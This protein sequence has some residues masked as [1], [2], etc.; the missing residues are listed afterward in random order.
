MHMVEIPQTLF[1][2]RLSG[3]SNL[4]LFLYD[5]SS[6]L[7]ITFITFCW[8][9]GNKTMSLSYW[10]AQSWTQHSRR[11]SPLLS[12]EKDPFPQ[13]AGHALPNAAQESIGCLCC[14]GTLLT[15][16]QL[17][18]HQDPHS[19]SCKAAFQLG[20]SQTVPS[21]VQDCIPFAEHGEVLLA[22]FCS[23]SWSLWISGNSLGHQPFPPSYI[24][25]KLVEGTPCP[26]IQ[27]INEDVKQYWPS[28]GACRT[29]AVTGH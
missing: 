20:I 2:S 13:P 19:L 15:H 28:T 12:R 11:V 3:L 4:S 25:C 16:V 14:R 10:G 9:H 27:V 8:T 1:C 26:I 22:H 6:S 23:F 17:G 24:S 21:K 7:L 5:G 18:V 29:T